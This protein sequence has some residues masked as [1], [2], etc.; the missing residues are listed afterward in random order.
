MKI[1]RDEV[2]LHLIYLLKYFSEGFRYAR[3]LIARTPNILKI[4]KF[5]HKKR[6]SL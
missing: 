2:Y 3:K 4:M 1:I 5:Y 6:L